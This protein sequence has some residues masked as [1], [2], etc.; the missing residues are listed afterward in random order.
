MIKNY[1]WGIPRDHLLLSVKATPGDEASADVGG[2]GN[3][4]DFAADKLKITSEECTAS[5]LNKLALQLVS[6]GQPKQVCLS[7]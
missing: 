7:Y 5:I 3:L 2:S 1:F 4:L 6:A